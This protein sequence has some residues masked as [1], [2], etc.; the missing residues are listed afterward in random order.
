MNQ[1]SGGGNS[2]QAGIDAGS[3]H[4]Q[5]DGY[6]GMDVPWWFVIEVFG[7][8]GPGRV[9]KMH[10]ELNPR[11]QVSKAVMAIA[12]SI[13]DAN[14][15]VAQWLVQG[16]FHAAQ[17]LLLGIQDDARERPGRET[18]YPAGARDNAETL[19]PGQY[20]WVI[21]HTPVCT[22]KSEDSEILQAG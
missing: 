9:G 3:R 13:G 21:G 5:G 10:P 11:A 8:K 15:V 12:S 14:Q 7:G 17:W 6:R 1:D 18:A 16:N 4:A 22:I 19:Q 20:Y 2:R